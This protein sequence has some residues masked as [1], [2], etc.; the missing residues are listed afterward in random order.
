MK[1]RHINVAYREEEKNEIITIKLEE[2]AIYLELNEN[3]YYYDAI[4]ILYTH[5]QKKINGL[6]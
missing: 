2:Y 4:R 1:N 6:S 5:T 3:Y